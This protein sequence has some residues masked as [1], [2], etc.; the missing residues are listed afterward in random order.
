MKTLI[1][2]TFLIILMALSA[3]MCGIEGNLKQCLYWAF[4]CALNAVVTYM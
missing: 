3:I 4:A 2:P 1:F